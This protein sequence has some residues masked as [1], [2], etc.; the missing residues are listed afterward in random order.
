VSC[1]IAWR[2]RWPATLRSRPRVARTQAY[3]P[4]SVEPME[5]GSRPAPGAEE[6]VA[7][8][9]G[10]LEKQEK[11]S[12]CAALFG[13]MARVLSEI[14]HHQ[15]PVRVPTSSTLARGL[16]KGSECQKRRDPHEM[17]P[18]M[19]LLA[20]IVG[21]QRTSSP[22]PVATLPLIGRTCR[23]EKAAFPRVA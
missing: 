2:T 18:R 16:D 19:I 13:R 21:C 22:R 17:A 11:E 5:G 14:D 4:V 23:A 10:H 8:L 7:T 20:S 3:E 1:K 12:P 6:S 15:R 9:R